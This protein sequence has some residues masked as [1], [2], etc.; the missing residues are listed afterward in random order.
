LQGGVNA[1]GSQSLFKGAFASAGS[2]A[3][4]QNFR[5]QT[6]NVEMRGAR[7]NS[8]LQRAARALNNF[9]VEQKGTQIRIVDEDGS[10]YTGK[11]EA[12]AQ[13][14]SRSLSN[15]QA[16]APADRSYAAHAIAPR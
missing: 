3:R 8:Q 12:I 14:D 15:R 4:N 9:Q 5:Q 7:F 16:Q 2:I 1:D 10:T 13:S 6:Q 11:I